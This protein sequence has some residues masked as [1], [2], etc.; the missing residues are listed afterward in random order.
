MALS[1]SARWRRPPPHRPLDCSSSQLA[2]SPPGLLILLT[3]SVDPPGLLI[4]PTG[5]AAPWIAHPP[6]W[7][8]LAHPPNW[9][10]LARPPNWLGLPPG[11]LSSQLARPLALARPPPFCVDSYLA[12]PPP[13]SLGLP[14][15]CA[16]APFALSPNWLIL[17]PFCPQPELTG[18]PIW[19]APT[20]DSLG[21]PAFP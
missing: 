3:G 4:L 14:T 12:C 10:G 9:L 15:G 16:S 8:G 7:L 11:L 20:P 17:A 5:S 13:G 18:L 21:L 19:I 6:N 2:Q 1:P